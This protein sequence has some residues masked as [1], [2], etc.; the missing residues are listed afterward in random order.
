MIGRWPPWLPE[1]HARQRGPMLRR[2]V[3][4]EPPHDP[5]WTG[6]QADVIRAFP[7]QAGGYALWR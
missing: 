1:R 3:P 6:L 2:G 7:Y 5:C 4:R